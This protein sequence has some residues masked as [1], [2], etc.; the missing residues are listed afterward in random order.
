MN[1]VGYLDVFLLSVKRKL[2]LYEDQTIFYSTDAMNNPQSNIEINSSLDAMLWDITDSFK[3]KSQSHVFSNSKISFGTETSTLKKFAVFN[4]QK[5]M[6]VPVSE[7]A[8]VNQNLLAELPKNMV[9]IVHPDFLNEALRLADHRRT[10]NGIESTIV[11][12]KQIYNEFSG[13]RQDV[14]AL[15]DFIRH[16]YLQSNSNLKY[17]LLFGRGSYDYKDRNSGNSNFVPVYE[18]RN[19]LEPLATYSSDDFFGFMDSNEGEWSETSAFDHTL[20]IGVG[21]IPCRTTE[22]AKAIVDK[23]IEYDINKKVKGQWKTDVVFTADDGDG[24]THQGQSNQLANQMESLMPSL[25]A[26]KI[27]VD[28]YPQIMK[29]FGQVSPDAR[30]TLFRAFHEGALIVNFTGHGSEHLWMQERLIDQTSVSTMENRYRYPFVITAT[31]EFGRNDDPFVASGAE[32][33]L[34]REQAGAIGL[35]T[36]SRPVNSATNFQLNSNFFDALLNKNNASF[37]EPI[38]TV[39]K[40]TKNKGTLGIANRNFS[41][42]GDPSMTIGI[43]TSEVVITQIINDQNESVLKGLTSY[44]IAGEIRK[45]NDLQVY[46]NGEAEIKI[47][48]KPEN[49]ITLGDENAPFQFS[50]YS[51]LLF[52]GKATVTDGTFTVNFTMPEL[53]EV[54]VSSGKIIT[55]AT[56]AEGEEA[57]GNSVVSISTINNSITDN[58]FPLAQLFIND[59]TFVNGGIANDNPFLIAQL[60]DDNGIDIS[61][62]S[63]HPITAVLDGD[64]TFILNNYYQLVNSGKGEISFQ[65]FG[66][67]KGKHQIVLTAYD[68]LGNKVEASVDFVVGDQGQLEVSDLVGWPNPFT[69]KVKIGFQQNRSGEDLE[70]TITITNIHGS[71]IRRFNFEMP[72]SFFNTEILE[73]DG[74][75]NNGGK[76]APGMYILRLKV[77]SLADGSNNEAY[78]KLIFRN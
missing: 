36:T 71:S 15:R 65:M 73:W 61:N 34:V 21:R 48:S 23:L 77:R 29:S 62:E 31:C 56:S 12:P 35:V 3:A 50:E 67:E 32:K 27:F 46:F 10:H 25:H 18:S 64:T 78:G 38:G 47:F 66:M 54:A 76:V 19:S 13:G 60:S 53:N 37:G 9:I 58:S 24:N 44:T 68:I 4:S 45:L 33:L 1:S 41:L 22:E 69:D 42:L 2:S 49:K 57:M 30:N 75:D 51:K 20:D 8:V 74:T 52:Q 40:F 39:F 70:G 26:K 14:S 43:P 72:S 28:S 11:T 16:L 55:Y 7:G 63:S 6:L 17:V 59:T 5:T